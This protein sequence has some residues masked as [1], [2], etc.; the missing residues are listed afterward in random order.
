M[1]LLPI[2][3]AYTDIERIK[4]GNPTVSGQEESLVHITAPSHGVSSPGPVPT[5]QRKKGKGRDAH[6]D[7]EYCRK[8]CPEP[9]PHHVVKDFDKVLLTEE[10]VRKNL[11][12]S[13]EAA[14][15][16][17]LFTGV[18]VRLHIF[19]TQNSHP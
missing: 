6:E 13:L 14:A 12:A 17:P 10:Q 19:Y 3:K 9:A 11:Q 5:N 18:A 8:I 7:G 16:R 15:A 1:V 2:F 4:L